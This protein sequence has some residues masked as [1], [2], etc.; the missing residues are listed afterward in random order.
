MS[1][2]PVSSGLI[3]HSH[4][5]VLEGICTSRIFFA[6]RANSYCRLPTAYFFEKISGCYEIKEIRTWIF[7]QIFQMYCVHEESFLQ[8]LTR[9][10]TCKN[11][12]TLLVYYLCKNLL[13][14]SVSIVLVFYDTRDETVTYVP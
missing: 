3:Y 12:Y 1:E 8:K 11:T 10:T 5:A 6:E 4:S 14:S 13:L 2:A 7:I 9:L